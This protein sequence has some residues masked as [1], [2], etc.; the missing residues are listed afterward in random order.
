MPCE[1]YRNECVAGRINPARL[2][3]LPVSTDAAGVDGALALPT[4]HG[5]DY[6]FL[7]RDA[8]GEWKISNFKK[9]TPSPEL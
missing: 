1:G 7:V 8:G 2:L 6:W 4:R 5:R 9:S 3:L